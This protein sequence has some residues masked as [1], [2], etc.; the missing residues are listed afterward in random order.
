LVH[1]LVRLVESGVPA[2][3]ILLLTFTRR[4][5]E[6]MIVENGVV[7][8]PAFRD[9]KL[10]TAPEIPEM[11]VHFIET[12]DGEGPQ[13]AKG[14]GEAPAICVAAAVANAIHNATGVR[15]YELPFTPEKVYRALKGL[16]GKPE[17]KSVA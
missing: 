4:A 9:Y 11:D 1:R 8:N 2:E 6:E 17:W 16:G 14:V 7:K 12:M 5:A 3:S 15:I 10:V 13:G